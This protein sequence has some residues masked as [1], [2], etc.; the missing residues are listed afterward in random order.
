MLDE[1]ARDPDLAEAERALATTK[2][3]AVADALPVPEGASPFGGST[4]TSPENASAIQKLSVTTSGRGSDAIQATF[5]RS[6]LT[7][8]PPLRRGQTLFEILVEIIQKHGPGGVEADDNVT[9][10]LI[11]GPE[12]HSIGT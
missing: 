2:T 6:T 5:L 12:S 1:I 10:E 3:Q 11:E 7:S 8:Q 4:L 9:L